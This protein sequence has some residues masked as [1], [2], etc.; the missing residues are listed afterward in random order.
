M[1]RSRRTDRM[2]GSRCGLAAVEFALIAPLILLLML[3]GT[4]LTI[5]MRTRLRIDEHGNRAGADRDAVPATSMTA[6]SAVCSP[7]HR[8]SP[9]RTPVTGLLG[10]TIITGIVNS[11]GKQTIA[12]QK[13]SA[14]ATFTSLFGTA[15]GSTPVLPNELHAALGR[16]A[17]RRRGVH[18]GVALG[19]ERQRD[20]HQ[21]YDIASVIYPVPTSPRLPRHHQV[22]EPAVT[23]AF[24]CMSG[25]DRRMPAPMAAAREIRPGT[26]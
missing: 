21:Q 10:T 4:D 5:F 24:C 26:E 19:S 17:D 15:T 22:R 2:L 8:P 23:A 18:L 16:C 11:G 1:S 7:R 20:E 9:A 13:R 14:S 25:F 3:A 12:W 6:I